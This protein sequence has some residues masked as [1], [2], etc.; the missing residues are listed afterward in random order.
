MNKPAGYALLLTAMLAFAVAGFVAYRLLGKEP[1]IPQRSGLRAASPKLTSEQ[2]REAFAK[3][4][5]LTL[6]DLDGHAQ[7]FSQWRGKV[8]VVNF[9]ASWC[10]PC[11]QEMPAFS[12]LQERYVQQGVQFVGVG[13]DEVDHLRAFVRKTPVSYPLL[14]ASLPISDTPALE[15]AGLPYTLVIARDGHIASRHLGRLDEAVLET[16]LQQ[17]TTAR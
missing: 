16:M 12:R 8:L 14:V 10:V 13:I 9:W 7:A 2:E 5:Q 11:V 1:P 6:P 15:I 3:L 17:Q 4:M